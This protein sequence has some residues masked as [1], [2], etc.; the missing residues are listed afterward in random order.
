MGVTKLARNH[1]L[2]GFSILYFSLFVM[3]IIFAANEL[4]LLF[5]IVAILITLLTVTTGVMLCI[6]SSSTDKIPLYRLG[7]LISIILSTGLGWAYGDMKMTHLVLSFPI[8]SSF[9]H[10]IGLKFVYKF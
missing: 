8:L 5:Q 2:L 10:I 4:I 6:V 3:H 9:I 1:T 7:F